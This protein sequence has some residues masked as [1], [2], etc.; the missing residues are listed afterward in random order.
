MQRR[1]KNETGNSRCALINDLIRKTRSH[2]IVKFALPFYSYAN[3]S[4][5]RRE[6]AQ[7]TQ[8]GLDYAKVKFITHVDDTNNY[9]MTLKE[10]KNPVVWYKIVL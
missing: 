6:L 4:I 5:E 8:S 1:T 7:F 2:C 3:E 9:H 10:G